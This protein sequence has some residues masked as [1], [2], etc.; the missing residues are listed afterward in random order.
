MEASK[1]GLDLIKEFEGFRSET[2]ICPTGHPTIGYGHKLKPGEEFPVGITRDKADALLREDVAGTETGVENAAKV[3]L[4]QNQFDALV[5][6][7][8]NVGIGNLI[9]STLLRKL[10]MGDYD[11][12]AEEFGRWVYGTVNGEKQRLPGLIRRREAETELFKSTEEG[13]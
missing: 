13:N 8:F 3:A 5:S 10:N 2:Y 7:A 9:R 6:F 4:N 11:G 1:K 12:A